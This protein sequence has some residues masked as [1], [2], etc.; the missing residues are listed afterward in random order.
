VL[1]DASHRGW[2]RLTV[3]LFIAA[4]ACYVPYHL[5]WS[6]V[7]PRGG[8]LPGLIY[9]GI[10]TFLMF[11]AGALGARR[12]LRAWNL[13]RATFWLK[14]HIWLGLLSYPLIL[15]HA[16]FRVG[17]ALTLALLVLFT[18][19]VVTGIHGLVV[20]HIVPRLMTVQVNVETMYEQIATYVARL[21]EE[22]VRTVTE[23]CGALPEAEAKEKEKEKAQEK[24]K[25]KHKPA[26]KVEPL[27]GSAPLKQFYL[28]EVGEFLKDGRGRLANVA[29][30]SAVFSHIKMLVPPTLHATLAQLEELCEERRQLAMQ[31]RLHHWMHGWL[32]VHLPAAAAL[33][34][35]TVVH[36]VVSVYY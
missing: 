6:P 29:I 1:I 17:G 13:G 34:V 35:L 4:T 27:E 8:S 23:V 31:V 26:K 24:D 11:F 14:G 30:R 10:G 9:G 7:G 2:I 36:A 28:A 21:C 20:Q 12:K 15:F 5:H 18:V 25:E 19:V 22:A 32:I 16:G 3:V 33:L